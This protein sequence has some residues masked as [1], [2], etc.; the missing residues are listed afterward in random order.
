M[1]GDDLYRSF[2]WFMYRLRRML[3]ETSNV[4]E[5]L[6]DERCAEFIG[7][8]LSEM[9]LYGLRAGTFLPCDERV[10]EVIPTSRVVQLQLEEPAIAIASAWWMAGEQIQER[11]RVQLLL[12]DEGAQYVYIADAAYAGRRLRLNYRTAHRIADLNGAQTTTF[13][14]VYDEALL[15]CAAALACQARAYM[16]AAST[17][18]SA[19][20]VPTLE[21]LAREYRKRFEDAFRARVARSLDW[22]DAALPTVTLGAY[23][24]SI[25]LR[26]PAGYVANVY[27]GTRATFFA[28]CYGSYD[29]NN[30]HASES[31]LTG[32]VANPEHDEGR[33]LWIVNRG[34]YMIGLASNWLYVNPS[35]P[36]YRFWFPGDN[37]VDVAPGRSF[38]LVYNARAQRWVSIEYG[39]PDH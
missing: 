3:G 34:Q 6:T 14:S 5:F 22:R 38:G 31:V 24:N 9:S 10:V 7:S 2:G 33:I 30:Q 18:V 19:N 15:S 8:A 27:A 4:P 29:P 36:Q 28:Y 23:V 39:T 35:L 17:T 16:L 21:W 1:P 12:D 25:V 37:S 26:L 11:A 13:S 20:A 32:I